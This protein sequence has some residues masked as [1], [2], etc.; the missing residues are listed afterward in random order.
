MFRCRRR[1]CPAYDDLFDGEHVDRELQPALLLYP[2]QH[3]QKVLA[4][5]VAVTGAAAAATRPLHV[6]LDDAVEDAVHGVVALLGLPHGAAEAAGEARRRPQVRR[7]EPGRQLDGALQLAEEHVAVLAPVANHGAHRGLG[8]ERGQRRPQLHGA[9]GRGR[10]G[11]R[12]QHGGHLL[13]TDGAEGGDAAR[14]EELRDGDLPELAPAAPVRREDDA[15]AAAGEHAHGGAQRPRR[16][17]RVVRPHHLPR[18]VPRRHHQRGHL[19]EPE[20]HDR[21]VAARQVAHRAV[22]E[23][24][25]EVVQAADDRQLPRPWRQPQ[26]AVAMRRRAPAPG[27]QHDEQRRESQAEV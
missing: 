25:G 21:P 4:V 6:L 23:L 26:P 16:E 13:L 24:A 18:R 20:H 12:P 10:R 7:V 17:R 3:V 1:R 2:Q 5:A 27:E 9:P 14:G 15:A 11:H 8:H 19:A 22:R